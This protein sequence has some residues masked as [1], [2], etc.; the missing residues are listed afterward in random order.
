M[1]SAGMPDANSAPAIVCTF[2][3]WP[4]TWITPQLLDFLKE[5]HMRCTFFALAMNFEHSK[6]GQELLKRAVREGHEIANHTYWH[7]RIPDFVGRTVR[8]K[9]GKEWFLDDQL[10][11]ATQAITAAIGHRPVFFRPRSWKVAEF[12]KTPVACEKFREAFTA[13][14]PP[15][16]RYPSHILYKEELMC[17]YGYT[18]QVLDDPALETRHRTTRDVNTTDYEFHA[19]YKKESK[20]A[21][22]ALASAMRSMIARR[23]RASVYVHI[24]GMHELPVTLEALKILVPEWEAK[25]YR[26]ITLREAHGL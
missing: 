24:L 20:Q 10:D 8:G 17:V 19:R 4:Q 9:N 1:P 3:D 6:E 2:D 21:A 25:G 26:T 12:S 5:H 15:K 11:R 13:G 14:E 22:D 7:A 18:I 23:E 16:V